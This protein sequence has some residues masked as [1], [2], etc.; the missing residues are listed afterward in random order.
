MF[1]QNTIGS[2]LTFSKIITGISKGL[3]IANQMIPLY[4][5]AK[6]MIS[7]AKK[8]M[9][10]I[11]EFKNYDTP[12]NNINN[13]NKTNITKKSQTIVNSSNPVFFQ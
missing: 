3:N 10:I 2:G 11:K 13:K 5:Q 9:S 8:V 12:K 1:G 7:N 6:P 4:Q